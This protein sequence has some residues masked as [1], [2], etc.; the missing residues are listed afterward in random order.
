MPSPMPEA[1]KDGNPMPSPMP[2]EKRGG[3]KLP[4]KQKQ[5]AGKGK[6]KASKPLLRRTF[7]VTQRLD[8]RARI[9][10]YNVYQRSDPPLAAK[11]MWSQLL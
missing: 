5:N 6:V 4:P 10:V 11:T 2:M 3:K 1:R 9:V 8:M 7:S